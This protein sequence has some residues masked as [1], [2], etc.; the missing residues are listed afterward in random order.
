MGRSNFDQLLKRYLTNQVSESEKIKIE[1]WLEIMKTEDTKNLELSKEDEEKLFERII[2]EKDNLKEIEALR[3]FKDASKAISR[4]GWFLRIAASIAAVVLII[5]SIQNFLGGD[6]VLRFSSNNNTEKIILNDG[7]IVW[8]HK[9][10]KLV[11]INKSKESIRYAELEGEALFEVAKDPAHPFLIKCNGAIV[12]VLGTSFSLKSSAKE[13]LLRVLTG[14]VNLSTEA[15][16]RGA[17][18]EPYEKAIVNSNGAIDKRL[19]R[20]EEVKDII[21]GTE[22]MMSFNNVSLHEVLK[23]LEK[24]FDLR[25]QLDNVMAGRCR[26]T[27]DL[28]DVSLDESLETLQEI[29][30][31]KFQEKNNYIGVTGTG[32]D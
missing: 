15:N 29:L 19:M 8:L 14:R 26:V 4:A 16:V 31:I 2:N 24:K 21:Y 12:K 18:I 5:Y 13:I 30:N 17:A 32:C 23:R 27:A 3:P 10:S 20:P 28:T 6:E 7:T 22:Y 11:Y 9:D 25:F 1:A